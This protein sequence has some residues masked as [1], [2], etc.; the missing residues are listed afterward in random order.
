MQNRKQEFKDMPDM[1]K[2]ECNAVCEMA[3]LLKQDRG[4]TKHLWAF[5]FLGR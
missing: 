2:G 3:G 4:G 1:T 5:L